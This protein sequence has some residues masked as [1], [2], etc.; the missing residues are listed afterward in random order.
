MTKDPNKI[1]QGDVT[2]LRITEIID[3]LKLGL[4]AVAPQG[5]RAILAEG[6]VTGHAHALP[7]EDVELFDIPED[8]AR[9][10]FADVLTEFR[11]VKY[12]RVKGDK[13]INLSHEEHK[14]CFFEPG[15]YLINGITEYDYFTEETRRVA[16]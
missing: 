1:Q 9:S 12:L 4:T 6:E 3:P 5:E 16:D 10:T 15:A 14:P 7:Q 11:G 8:V 13:P 2:A